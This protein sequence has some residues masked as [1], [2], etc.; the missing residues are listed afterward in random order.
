MKC[1]Y[2]NAAHAKLAAFFTSCDAKEREC[3]SGKGSQPMALASYYRKAKDHIVRITPVIHMGNLGTALLASSGVSP[4][5]PVTNHTVLN[6]VGAAS[7]LPHKEGRY[8]ATGPK[9][10]A[11][12]IAQMAGRFSHFLDAQEDE[13]EE[14]GEGEG[15]EEEAAS[16]H[17]EDKGS[18]ST[19]ASERDVRTSAYDIATGGVAH[20]ISEDAVESALVL[21]RHSLDVAAAVHS[22]SQARV[23]P[24]LITPGFALTSTAAHVALGLAG[25]KKTIK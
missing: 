16:D 24:L 17:G 25:A 5:S 9:I 6:L 12:S 20:L 19:R 11:E 13:G 4:T 10:T 18:Q 23:A 22:S 8:V 2:T 15:E 1:Y 3:A 21:V 7:A 14:G